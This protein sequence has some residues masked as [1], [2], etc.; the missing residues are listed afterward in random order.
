MKRPRRDRRWW[1]LLQCAVC[2]KEQLRAVEFDEPTCQ[3]EVQMGA[4]WLALK[5]RCHECKTKTLMPA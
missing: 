4:S 2:G 3:E 5:Y 1:L